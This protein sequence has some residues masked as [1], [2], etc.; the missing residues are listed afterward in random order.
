MSQ[1]AF[2]GDPPVTSDD[3]LIH[4]AIK[5]IAG[6]LF[7]PDKSHP[8]GAP[9]P[10][11]DAPNEYNGYRVKGAAAS[12]IVFVILI[13]VGR[14]WIRKRQKLNYGVDDYMVIPAAVSI[15]HVVARG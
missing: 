9:K 11:L 14:F 13:T 10:S 4:L 8:Y 2:L 3:K 6:S 7:F 1:S 12:M 15:A 5:Y